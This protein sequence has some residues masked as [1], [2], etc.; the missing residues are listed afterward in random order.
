MGKTMCKVR[1]ITLNYRTQQDVNFEVMANM[2]KGVG[3]ET[4]TVDIPFKIVRD[5]KSKCVLTRSEIVNSFD[6]YPMD[7][8]CVC[9]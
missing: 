9:L 7:F 8:K 2:V 6:T 1:G 4:I 5:R 3:P